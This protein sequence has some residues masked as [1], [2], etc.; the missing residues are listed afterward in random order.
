MFL[1]CA[2]PFVHS[3]NER[4][5]RIKHVTQQVQILIDDTLTGINH[6]YDYIG[7]GYRIQRFDH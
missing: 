6:Q 7:I 3:N 2:I 5:S 1:F 4:T